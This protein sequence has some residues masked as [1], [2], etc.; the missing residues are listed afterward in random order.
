MIQIDD[1][2]YIIDNIE[3]IV[4]DRNSICRNWL[5]LFNLRLGLIDIAHRIR[6]KEIRMLSENSEE[7]KYT[8]IKHLHSDFN[9]FANSL[10]S[11]MKIIALTSIVNKENWQEEDLKKKKNIRRYKKY[12]RSYI[13]TN[14][15]EI[16]KWRNKVGA[17]ISLTDPEK[18]KLSTMLGSVSEV[19]YFKP[20][21]YANG[22]SYS[23]SL[24]NEIDEEI[25]IWSLTEVYERLTNRLFSDSPLEKVNCEILKPT[26]EDLLS[27]AKKSTN[28]PS[29]SFILDS[30]KSIV[31]DKNF[32][33]P[34]V[35]IILNHLKFGIIELANFVRENEGER[36]DVNGN[37][38]SLFCLQKDIAF[39]YCSFLWFS[40]SLVCYLKLI[41]FYDIVQK[42]NWELNDLRSEDIQHEYTQHCNQYVKDLIPQIVKWRN[43][44]GA[45]FTLTDPRKDNLTTMI[46]SIT[47]VSF[48]KPFYYTN[49]I[50]WGVTDG[51]SKKD[52]NIS[53]WSA[54]EEYEKLTER[55]F[56]DDRIPT[57]YELQQEKFTL[58][59]NEDLTALKMFLN[60][61]NRKSVGNISNYE[62]EFF[63]GISILEKNKDLDNAVRHFKNTI[64]MNKFNVAGWNG[65]IATYI[66]MDR[67]YS[68]E[69]VIKKVL[70]MKKQNSLTYF[71]LGQILNYKLRKPE[72]AIYY[73]EKIKMGEEHYEESQKEI[74]F[75]RKI[76][77]SNSL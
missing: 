2:K 44:V 11:Y 23:T 77:A 33:I 74:Q 27:I 16:I 52:I 12:C 8:I 18:D 47:E 35:G 21:F 51:S 55:F 72:I 25:P 36:I 40:T 59:P 3:N 31:W 5:I 14:I 70:S 69:L 64:E 65:L 10:L 22:V 17:H 63:Q 54:T 7:E 76:T 50:S 24:I 53:Q 39:T 9:W 34:D 20:F 67:I 62:N 42:N 1:S 45:H 13:Y 75:L 56:I 28:T 60:F 68:A 61:I 57:M 37:I 48:L 71:Y 38:P 43:K 49:V 46:N 41:A 15:P 19:K 4:W 58:P 6:S 66:K 32:I 73:Y 26:K 29:N 30:K